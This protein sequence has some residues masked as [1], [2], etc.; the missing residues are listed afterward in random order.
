MTTLRR[1][2]L[3][4]AILRYLIEHPDA[5][6]TA[7]GIAD[8]WVPQVVADRRGDVENMLE[9]LC[10]IGWITVIERSGSRRLYGLARDADAAVRSYLDP[11][12]PTP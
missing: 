3:S 5:R 6:D 11:A 1:D 4:T 12:G 7:D 9:H 2:A 8:W 10:A